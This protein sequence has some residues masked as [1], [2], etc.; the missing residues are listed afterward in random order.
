MGAVGEDGWVWLAGGRALI[1][2]AGRSRLSPME[3]LSLLLRTWNTAV[4]KDLWTGR[5]PAVPTVA[6]GTLSSFSRVTCGSEMSLRDSRP[7][8]PPSGH[9]DSPGR[10]P[11]NSCRGGDGRGGEGTSLCTYGFQYV[12]CIT[13]V[14][15]RNI[16]D[17][18]SATNMKHLN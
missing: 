11:E 9:S 18:K 13:D 12:M 4:E 10:S 6:G 17:T 7:A 8:D 16:S 5:A 2:G 14:S 1:G 3:G 15:L